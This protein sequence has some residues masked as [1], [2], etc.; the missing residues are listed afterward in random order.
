MCSG[1]HPERY[2]PRLRQNRFS[3]IL[4]ANCS[5]VYASVDVTSCTLSCGFDG[6]L[7]GDTTPFYPV[8]KVLSCPSSALLDEDTVEGLECSSLTLGEACVVTCTDGY[9]AAVD[10]ETTLTFVLNPELKSL[11]LEGSAHSCELAPCDLSTLMPPST[12]SRDCPNTVF[13]ESGTATCSHGNA[14]ILGTASSIVLTCGSDGA[15]VGDPTLPYPTCEA[16]T[17]SIG[18]LLPNGSLT[19][20]NGASWTIGESCA[21]TF[22]EGCQAANQTSG[23]LTCVCTMK[24]QVTWFWRWEDRSVYRWFVL[25][26]TRQRVSATSAMTSCLKSVVWPLVS[27]VRS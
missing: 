12:V 13:E 25:L 24:L 11:F 3:G 4:F 23:T 26:M 14:A 22:V 6:F 8:C 27:G 20:V 7:V 1:R 18:D 16:L 10:T 17:C 9:T 5:D 15:L 21:V 2:E 19:G